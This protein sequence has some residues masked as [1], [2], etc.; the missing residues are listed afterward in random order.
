MQ[1]GERE[2][3]GRGRARTVGG[4]EKKKPKNLTGGDWNAAGVLSLETPKE[5]YNSVT[6]A[7][8]QGP[9]KGTGGSVSVTKKRREGQKRR[10]QKQKGRASCEHELTRTETVGVG[11]EA[12]AIGVAAK[13]FLPERQTPK[14]SKRKNKGKRE[15][16]QA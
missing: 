5:K 7:W 8:T 9:I 15:R 13:R 10:L 1:R 12:T 2:Q 3:W 4:L 11:Q 6:Q 16:L 14:K